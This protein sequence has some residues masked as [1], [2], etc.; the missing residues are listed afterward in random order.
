M[1]SRGSGARVPQLVE[2]LVDH[3]LDLVERLSGPRRRDDHEV[4]VERLRLLDRVDVLRDLQVVNEALVE[5]RVLAA[6]EQVRHDVHL[7][8]AG[9][10]ERRRVPRQEQARQ[11]HA[12]G[13]RLLLDAVENRRRR[14][15]RRHRLAGRHVAE[16]LLD[17][18]AGA[19]DVDVAGDHEARVA[20]HVVGAEEP[21]DVLE[22]RR[23]EIF[24]RS[25]RRPAI[26]MSGRIEHRRQLDERLAVRL[27][28]DALTLLVLDNIALAVDL[29]GRLVVEEE[30]HA[31]G[32]EEQRQLERVRGDVLVIV[33]AIVGGRAVVVA[34][35]GLEPVVELAFRHVHRS[36]EHDVLEEMREAGAAGPLVAR[37]DVIPDV[38]G[39]DRHARVAM[40]DHVQ[41]VG[42]LELGVG[43][44]ERRA[45]RA[46]G[47]RRTK[48]Q[49]RE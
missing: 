11:L 35:G 2:L 17:Q 30:A 8:V 42:Q 21:R 18:L 29:V 13:D 49:S 12:I 15:D 32:L 48:Q 34:A 9:L 31:I 5:A 37:A 14:V 28:V 6:R 10:Q 25:D 44:R 39:H 47:H 7:G 27:V 20:G 16:P 22:A 19:G 43:N 23:G 4:A 46:E 40:Q 26:R 3:R 45:L 41:A 38:H 24:H 36:F 33:G 1:I